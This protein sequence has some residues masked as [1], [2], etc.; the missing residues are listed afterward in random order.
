MRAHESVVRVQLL[1]VVTLIQ[2][3]GED[4]SQRQ[5]IRAA[6]EEGFEE[7]GGNAH[8]LWG[9]RETPIV[10]N[11]SLSPLSLSLSLSHSLYFN[12]P[13]SFSLSLSLSLSVIHQVSPTPIAIAGGPNGGSFD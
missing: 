2:Y 3:D 9:E 5:E 8:H 10:L 13:L 4:L 1:S 12:L 7:S 11:L 6:I